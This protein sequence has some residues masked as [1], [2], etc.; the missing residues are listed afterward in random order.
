MLLTGY[1]DDILLTGSD[2]TVINQTKEYLK[3][4]FLTKD[5]KKPKYFLDI[6][7]AYARDRMALSE[8][9]YALDLLQEIGLIECKL[10]STAIDESLAF[11]DSTSEFFE[12]V[13]QYRRMIGKLDFSISLCMNL[14]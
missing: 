10:E 3:T 14:T 12:D 13:G 8:R 9:K 4:H 1:V 6:E 5:M 11:W 2:S 7:F